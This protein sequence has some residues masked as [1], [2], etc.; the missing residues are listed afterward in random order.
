MGRT[1]GVLGDW[2]FDTLAWSARTLGSVGPLRRN[3]ADRAERRLR[4]KS[5]RPVPRHPPAVE[6][7]KAAF[8]LALLHT[9]ER[10]L[11]ERRLGRPALRALLK[12]VLSDIQ[13]HRGGESAKDRFRARHEGICVV[14]A[15]R[16]RIM[17]NAH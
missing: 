8:S 7:D 10:A 12:T 14:Q 2:T 16:G 9:A 4:D 15:E 13:V 17:H 3:L 1:N 5:S 11:A 6:Q